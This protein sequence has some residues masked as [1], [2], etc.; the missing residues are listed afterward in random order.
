MPTIH[1]TAIVDPQAEIAATAIIGPYCVVGA[2]VVLGERVEL[3]SHVVVEGRTT[4]GDDT[5]IF[6]FASIGH[7]PQDLKYH[8]EPSTLEVGKNNQ[9]REYVTMQPGTEGGGMVTRVGDNCLFMAS[10][11]VAHDC[12]L[13]DHVIM[14]NNATLAGHVLVGNHAFLGGLSA[15]HQFVRIGKHAM[16]GGMSG[17]E[18]DVIPFGM[19]IGNRAH[20]NG[21]N[22]V[23]L[24]R[25]GFS[26][27]EIHTLRNAYRLL[28]A[29]EGTLQE[30]VADV[31]EQFESNAGVMEIVEF[32][33]SD[34]S[35]S[36]CT[37]GFE[38]GK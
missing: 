15:V 17:V 1:P 7:Q 9:I 29:P 19:V 3:L 32:I 13:G 33:R 22:I 27:D 20:L 26:R 10:A 37:P 14:A 28:F 16:I 25:R 35:R 18:A 21:L 2:N 11:H 24:R 36:L 8:G 30:R 23:G 34:S 38:D 5:R 31:A 6:P 4:I 12:I